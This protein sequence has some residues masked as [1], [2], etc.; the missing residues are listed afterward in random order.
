MVIAAMAP[1]LDTVFDLQNLL[2]TI[3]TGLQINMMGPVQ[4][5]SDFILDI[6]VA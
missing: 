4:F 6:S 5:A 2:A 1:A 3:H